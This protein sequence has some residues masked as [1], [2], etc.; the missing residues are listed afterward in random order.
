[1]GAGASS[2]SGGLFRPSRYSN[3]NLP[4]NL[5]VRVVPQQSAWVVERFG[6]FHKVLEPGLHLLIPVVDVIA[7][8]H[9]LK[10]EAL[11]IGNQTAIT[12]D[13]VTISIDGVLY[14]RVVD[15]ARASYGVEDAIFAVTQLAQTTMRSELGKITLDKTFEERDMLNRKIVEAINEA[16]AAWGVECLRYEIRDISPPHSIRSA[17][18]MQAEAERK[19]R[20]EITESEGEREAVA[21]VAEGKKR[22]VV[23][24]AEGE[25]AAIVARARATADG[26]RQVTTALAAQGGERAA[27]LRVAEQ[28]VEAFAGIAKRGNTI[29]L[30]ANAGDAASMV[31]SAMATYGTIQRGQQQLQQHRREGDGDGDDGDTVGSSAVHGGDGDDM[32]F[33]SIVDAHFDGGESERASLL[34][35]KIASA[36]EELPSSS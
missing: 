4:V 8:V 34:T 24:E 13:N 30:P 9:S 19:K 15:P 20:A 6:K 10:E 17:M 14:V 23:L 22:A 26:L 33:H 36:Q 3:R 28:Y 7:Y 32:D 29:V 31:S 5:G 18:D 16:A 21:N 25:A 27:A 11:P 1:M 2:G 35:D 12:R